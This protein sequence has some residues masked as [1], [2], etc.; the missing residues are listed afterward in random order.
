MMDVVS[1]KRVAP[2]PACVI[3][4]DKK[5][6]RVTAD[7]AHEKADGRDALEDKLGSDAPPPWPVPHMY[8]A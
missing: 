3:P 6:F 7:E 8:S 1:P 2:G 4:E 5:I